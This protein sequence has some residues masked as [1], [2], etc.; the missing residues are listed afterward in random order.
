MKIEEQNLN[1]PQTPQ[2]NITA[3]SGSLLD[4]TKT[5]DCKHKYKCTLDTDW[6]SHYVCEKCGHSYIL[7]FD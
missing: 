6:W 7:D 4:E 2:L 1:E 3:V 5:E